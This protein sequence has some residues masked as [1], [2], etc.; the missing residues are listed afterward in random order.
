MKNTLLTFVCY[1]ILGVFLLTC[2]NRAQ[3]ASPRP[4][5][6]AATAVCAYK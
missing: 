4:S 5:T 6:F 1:L 3:A 2:T